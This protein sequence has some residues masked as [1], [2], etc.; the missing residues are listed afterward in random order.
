MITYNKFIEFYY[1]YGRC[2]NSI[3]RPRK[4]LNDIQLKSKYDKYIQSEENNLD[5]AVKNYKKM[6]N[7]EKE[8][9]IDIT[10]ENLKIAVKTRDENVCRI[11]KIVFSEDYTILYRRN[12]SLIKTLEVA[13]VLP[14]GAY[15]ELKYE[16]DNLVLLNKYSHQMLDLYKDPINGK[17]I[18]RN[19]QLDWWCRILGKKQ[20]ERLK[21]VLKIKK[22]GDILNGRR[23]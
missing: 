3:N 21:K 7:K 13:H 6:I 10:W 23:D 19:H 11:L 14:R 5:K 22:I 4:K 1:T 15:P 18:N 8:L 2:L 16:I 20:L 12:G 9:I 17:D